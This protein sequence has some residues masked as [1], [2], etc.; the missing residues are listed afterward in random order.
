[1]REPAIG[2]FDDLVGA[3]ED[4]RRHGEAERLRDLEIDDQLEGGRCC[5][6]SSAGLAPLR[7]L[8]A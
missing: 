8:P 7:I 3:G 6:G 4:R 1:M 2:S 5:T